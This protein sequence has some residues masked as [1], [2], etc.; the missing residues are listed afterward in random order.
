MQLAIVIPIY[1]EQEILP[2]LYSRLK[3]VCDGIDAVQWQVIYVNDGSLD[4]SVR[5]V[6]DQHA[7]DSRF[8]LVNLS[9]NFGHQAAISA[10][11]AHADADAVVVMDADLQDPPEVIPKLIDCWRAGGEV[12]RA[13]RT[14]RQERGLR[15]L[16]FSAF[17]A[18]FG[19][20]SDF[21]IPA[22]AGVFGLLDRRA[23]AEF[24]RLPERNRFIPGL[25]SWI[26]FDQRTVSYDRM[27]RQAGEPKQSLG[28]LFRY[29]MDGVF[30]FSYKPLRIMTYAGAGISGLGFATAITFI[31]RR[32][33]GFEVAQTGFTTLI[34][35]S[36]TLGGV[37]LIALGLLGEYLGR[38]YD[39]VKQRPLYIVGRRHGISAP[40]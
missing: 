13:E 37:Q 8:C 18:I 34:T 14:S 23:V 7:E 1:N 25:R 6:L 32:L 40:S 10:G 35:V 33:A 28:R 22:Q 12:V 38:I 17:H 3:Q 36:L 26:G 4:D 29:A 30:G 21:P 9:R 27:D 11:L 19:W 2:E 5:V 39:E 15:R 16:G 31:V 24:N 20:I